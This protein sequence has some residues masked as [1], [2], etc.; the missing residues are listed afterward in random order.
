[1]AQESDPVDLSRRLLLRV[2]IADGPA[3]ETGGSR[4]ECQKD[5]HADANRHGCVA[6]SKPAI[7]ATHLYNPPWC[8]ELQFGLRIGGSS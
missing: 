4:Q 3:D 5:E 6:E 2:C 1:L 7:I 8:G